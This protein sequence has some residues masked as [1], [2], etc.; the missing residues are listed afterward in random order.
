MSVDVDVLVVGAGPT[1]LVLGGELLRRGLRVRIVDSAAAPTTLSKAIAVHART[2]E[3]FADLGIAEEA[4]ARGVKLRGATMWAGGATIASVDF[5]EL[6]TAYPFILSI[7][8]A[9]TEAVLET[10]LHARGGAVERKTTLISLEQD[11]R[12]VTAKLSKEHDEEETVR[13]SSAVGCDGAHSAVRKALGIPFEGHTYEEVF[14][15]ADVRLGGSWSAPPDR[16]STYFAEDGIAACFAMREG[17]WRVIVS[18]TGS[19]PEGTAPTA[20]DVERLLGSRCGRSVQV[21]DVAW[22]APFRIH[23]RQVAR[24]RDGRVFL[25]GDAA[26]I[27]SPAGG[28]GMNTGIQDAHN[29]AWKLALAHEGRGTEALLA[30]Y[31]SERHAIG[32]ALLRS[33]DIATRIGSLRGAAPGAIRNAIAGFMTGFEPVRRRLAEEI[34]ELSVGYEKSPIV[35]EHAG[36]LLGGRFGAGPKP[37]TRAPDAKVV[38]A[39]TSGE[40]TLS[41]IMDG[42]TFTLLLFAGARPSADGHATLARAAS[43]ARRRWPSLV[44]P[45]LVTPAPGRPVGIPDDLRVLFD[46]ARAAEQRYGAQ[47]ECLYLVRPDLYVGFRSRPADAAALVR[48]LEELL[49]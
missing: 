46:G 21:S 28:Q 45:F 23:C 3:I 49:R 22:L 17:R 14:V 39:A 44:V 5:D 15:L 30:S 6:E 26:H 48:H 11:E 19:L 18:A 47:T 36:S 24:Y 37:G 32:K 13:A 2:L 12:G 38:D 43:E 29:L 8:Q 4:I 31:E 27:H 25:A 7:A 10:L 40:T 9:E 20:S 42:R 1:G 16:I 34:S 35:G 41:A 33:T